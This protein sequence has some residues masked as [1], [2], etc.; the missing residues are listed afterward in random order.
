M[1]AVLMGGERDGGEPRAADCAPS[2]TE[3]PPSDT[4]PPP[5]DTERRECD[6][7]VEASKTTA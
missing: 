2:D 6:D 4:E 1:R 5:S 3:P 7:G